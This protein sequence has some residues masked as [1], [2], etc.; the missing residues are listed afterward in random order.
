[1]TDDD[2]L[3]PSDGVIAKIKNSTSAQLWIVAAVSVAFF[4]AMKYIGIASDCGPN[5]H[6]GQC[7]MSTF[8][9]KVFGLLG[10]I[11]IWLGLSWRILWTKRQRDRRHRR[12]RLHGES[13]V[14][15][16]YDRGAAMLQNRLDDDTRRAME[17]RVRNRRA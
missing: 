11:I 14:D 16:E 1:M 12:Q 9:M 2:A 6:D 5:S 8:F 17:D 7:G 10:G 15:P 3:P 4:F 13:I